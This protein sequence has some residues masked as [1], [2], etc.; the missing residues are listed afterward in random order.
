M[1]RRPAAS[2]WAPHSIWAA[3]CVTRSQGRS[4]QVPPSSTGPKAGRQL[5]EPGVN[6]AGVD[7][8]GLVGSDG[9]EG[10]PSEFAGAQPGGVVVPGG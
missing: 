1:P 4:I 2:K 3:L 7:A 9:G 10:G 5:V 8:D 6:R